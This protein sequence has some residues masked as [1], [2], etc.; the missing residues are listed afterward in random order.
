M[1]SA[2]TGD[3]RPLGR[4]LATRLAL[5]MLLTAVASMTAVVL[6]QWAIAER[7]RA[8]LPAEIQQRLAE[9]RQAEPSWLI[10]RTPPW[11]PPPGARSSVATGT[12]TVQDAVRGIGSVQD[13]QWSGVAI[14][15][16]VAMLL[17]ALLALVFART[18]A[19][20]VEAVSVAATRLAG[21]DLAS[22]ASLPRSRLGTSGELEHLARDFNA[23]AASLERA[24]AQR[25][26]MIADIAHELRTPLTVMRLRLDAVRDGLAELDDAEVER[27]ARQTAL[28]TR[29]VED[30]RTLSLADAGRLRLERTTVDLRELADT[31]VDAHAPQAQAKG[32]TLRVETAGDAPAG[33]SPAATAGDRDRLTQ[34]L[35]N[36]LDNAVRVA[37]SGSEVR[38]EVGRQG[39]AVLLRVRDAGPGIAEDDLAHVFERF[40]Q[41]RS[42]R[43]DTRG[44]SG[45]GL[46]IVRTLVELHGGRVEVRC[47]P[48]GG[49]VFTIQLP[50]IGDAAA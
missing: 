1:S 44:A 3:R 7:A 25:T 39:D 47:P 33:A 43:R 17:S 16:G 37:P 48:E 18:I 29:L 15:L 8:Q 23:M 22:R 27:L 30:L 50:C 36:L 6:T 42:S 40:R 13:A 46:A 26:A 10:L 2:A 45:L 41:G 35:A 32:V 24:E 28:L 19:R 34:V 4:R 5:A 11:A 31:V 12:V 14:G 38:V 49:S 9:V 21:G 20:P